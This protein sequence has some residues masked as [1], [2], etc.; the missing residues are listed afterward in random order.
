MAGVALDEILTQVQTVIRALAL[1][2]IAEDSVVAQLVG[3]AEQAKG[4]NLSAYPCCVIFPGG[5]EFDIG[6]SNIRDD[7]A[8]PVGV[9]LLVKEQQ[10]QVTHRERNFGWRQSIKR[11]FH[12]KRLL[13]L[14]AGAGVGWN[15]IV[16]PGTPGSLPRWLAGEHAQLLSIQVQ[17]REP[18]T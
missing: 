5:G 13:G 18:R 15:C 6:G 16:K 9:A 3:D 12:Q 2:G 8:Y 17:V 10:E 11:A 1:P 4:P 7:W 14:S